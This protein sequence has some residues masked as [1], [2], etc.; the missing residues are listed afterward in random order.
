MCRCF[1]NYRE[2]QTKLTNCLTGSVWHGP[3]LSGYSVVLHKVEGLQSLF[4]PGLLHTGAA[5]AL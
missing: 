1:Q 5:P 2:I 4:C 3:S